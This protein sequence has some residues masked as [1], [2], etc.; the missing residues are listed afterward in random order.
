LPLLSSVSPF[1]L[2]LAFLLA[3]AACVLITR[4][5]QQQIGGYTGDVLGAAQ[6]AAEIVMLMTLSAGEGSAF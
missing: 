5:A 3:Y 2:V 1:A 6:Q 4:V